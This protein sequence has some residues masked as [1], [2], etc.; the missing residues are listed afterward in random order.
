MLADHLGNAGRALAALDLD[1]NLVRDPER[2]GGNVLG[3][4]D[5]EAAAQARAGRHER[6]MA[7]NGSGK[8][9]VG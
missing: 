6:Q 4:H 5:A 3:F 9:Y 2:I 7:C 8:V 1:R